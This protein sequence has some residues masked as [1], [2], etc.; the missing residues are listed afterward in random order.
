LRKVTF[1]SAQLPDND[2]L[3]KEAWIDTLASGVARV[4]VEPASGVRFEGALAIM[5]VHDCSV[6]TVAA[7]IRSIQRGAADIASDGRDTVLL[8]LNTAPTRLRLSQR[9]RDVD[10]AAG[11]AVLID[12]S[13]PS[14]LG[15]TTS[16]MSR[17]VCVRVPR[18]LMREQHGDFEDRFLAPIPARSG[19]VSL[20]RAYVETLLAYSGSDEVL[21]APLAARHL[22]E[23]AAA[24][25]RP[26]DAVAAE[27]SGQL[28]ARLIAIEREIDRAF[29]EPG[30]ALATL[31][32]RLGI[33]PRHVQRLLATQETSF[34][35]EVMQRR[36]CRSRDMLASTKYGDM[37][38]IEIAHECGFSTVSH[39]HRAFRQRFGMTPGDMREQSP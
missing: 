36:L 33:T 30:F 2:R 11:D 8:M 26:P 22:V 9:G 7:T 19:A 12:Q 4:S 13:E 17:M 10:F 15:A 23:L 38:I 18:G 3:R 25:T 32:R 34:V 39:F 29:S 20:V 5:L 28:A 6:S 27:Q 37:S 21:S 31:S 35:D 24:A 16:A 14:D 1:D